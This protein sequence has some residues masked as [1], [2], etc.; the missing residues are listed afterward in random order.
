MTGKRSEGLAGPQHGWVWAVL[1]HDCRRAEVLDDPELAALL[2]EAG[3]GEVVHYPIS[4]GGA[5]ADAIVLDNAGGAELGATASRLS[6]GG[7]LAVPVG[8]APDSAERVSRARRL[9]RRL[10]APA[11]A[12]V[13]ELAARRL[14]RRLRAAGLQTRRIATGVRSRSHSLAVA[15]AWALPTGGAIV[16]GSAGAP[17][18]SSLERALTEVGRGIEARP[19]ALAATVR[20]SGTLLVELSTPEAGR[21]VLRLAAGPAVPLLDASHRNV[22]ALEASAPGAVRR[23]LVLPTAEGQAGLTRYVV[24]PKVRGRRPRGLRRGLWEDCLEFL[25]ALRSD[26]HG[27]AAS[28]QG[29]WAADARAVA[30]HL[31]A[32]ERSTLE[33]LERSLR[34]RLSELPAGWAHGDFWLGN[35]LTRRGRL[36]AVL[37]WDAADPAAPPMLDLLHLIAMGE[38]RLRRLP[39]GRRCTSV[40]WPLARSGGDSRVRAYCEATG[41]PTDPDTLEALAVT[42]W[43][44]RVG[45]DLATFADRAGRRIWMEDN[46]HRPLDA[47]AV[48]WVRD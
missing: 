21:C 13:A 15:G 42:Y 45:R 25:A 43:L 12:L 26:T 41:T 32:G 40:L 22:R 34:E 17:R 14:E 35:L 6:P 29:R 11:A 23:R 44:S 16:A 18:E 4:A 37:D 31:D 24:E 5:R 30:P 38:Y 3:V 39:H 47:L 7:M 10:R 19:R 46:V 20:G 2:K 27:E 28:V 8:R 1:P 33:R 36:V 9:V 48:R